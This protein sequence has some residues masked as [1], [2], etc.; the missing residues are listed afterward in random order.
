[1]ISSCPPCHSHENGNPVDGS[2]TIDSSPGSPIGAG[3]DKKKF[4]LMKKKKQKTN[5]GV[6][7][8]EE[9]THSDP[10]LVEGEESRADAADCEKCPEHLA[11]WKRAL[12]DYENLKA[13]IDKVKSTNR[14][15]IRIDLALSLLPVMDNFDQAVNFAP[16]TDDKSIETWLQ[17]VTFI[18]K[19]FEDV[20]EQLGL[21]KINTSVKFDIDI[22]EAVEE[23]ESEDHE[24]GEI[25]EV[26][27]AGWR[28]GQ[29]ILRP[30]KV[31]VSK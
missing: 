22:H 1:M 18:K 29:R 31:V 25:I 14:D 26:R 28:I 3:D 21:E 7:A 20:F 24:A 11:G 6:Q 23:R 9:G 19:Q 30:S 5:D 2:S 8:P 17:G 12:A 4:N 15:Q 13:D 27:Q 16:Q 10:E